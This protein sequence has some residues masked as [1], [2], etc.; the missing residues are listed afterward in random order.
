M[1]LLA[2]A[3]VALVSSAVLAPV[4]VNAQPNPPRH[5]GYHYRWKTV[6]KVRWNHHRKVRTCHKVRVRYWR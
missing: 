2:V 4:A 6:C 5:G 1:K 3:A